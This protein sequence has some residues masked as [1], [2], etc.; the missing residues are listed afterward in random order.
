MLAPQ[1]VSQSHT[2]APP[3]CR[4]YQLHSGVRAGWRR[5][6]P[7][8]DWPWRANQWKGATPPGAVCN[9][10]TALYAGLLPARKPTPAPGKSAGMAVEPDH[11]RL[12]AC[13]PAPEHPALPCPAVQR[14]FRFAAGTFLRGK[15]YTCTA[16]ARNA[17]GVSPSS[18]PFQYTTPR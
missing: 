3:A 13:M 1:S 14:R 8:H 6:S 16:K 15:T 11:P 18:A 2:R 9:A 4:Y 12:I 17:I 5:R 10:N 7:D